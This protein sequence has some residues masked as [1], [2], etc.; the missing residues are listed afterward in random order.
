MVLRTVS[1]QAKKT[2]NAWTVSDI[3]CFTA[4]KCSSPNANFS[5]T[6]QLV[7]IYVVDFR[8]CNPSCNKANTN[9]RFRL[10]V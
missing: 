3:R 4:M 7:L 2:F 6:R 9:I 5:I 10:K 1:R 8:P